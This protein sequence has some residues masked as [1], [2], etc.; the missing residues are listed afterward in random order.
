ESGAAGW[1]LATRQIYTAANADANHQLA[2]ATDCDARRPAGVAPLVAG[3]ELLGLLVVDRLEESDPSFASKLS[4]L[5]SLAALSMKN[6]QLSRRLEDVSLRDTLTGLFN[7]SGLKAATE[8]ALQQRGD[9]PLAVFVL[10]L[11]RFDEVNV[12]FGSEAGDNVLQE[13]A[14][15][16]RAALPAD[17]VV[18]RLGGARFAALA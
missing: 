13:M 5:A 11:D 12:E 14:R 3:S 9:K 16:W 18:A 4:V 1:V 15:L 10:E 6:A 2:V 7:R 8:S 17:A